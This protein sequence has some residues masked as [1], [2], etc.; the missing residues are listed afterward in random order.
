MKIVLNTCYLCLINKPISNIHYK[1]K[2]GV[3]IVSGVCKFCQDTVDKYIDSFIK[4]KFN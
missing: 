1:T 4:E 3:T 2:N